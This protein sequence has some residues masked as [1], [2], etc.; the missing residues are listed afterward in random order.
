MRER[1]HSIFMATSEEEGV[2]KESGDQAEPEEW[3]FAGLEAINRACHEAY[4]DQPKRIQRSA[5]TKY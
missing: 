1:R 4:P 3:D 5:V 2:T